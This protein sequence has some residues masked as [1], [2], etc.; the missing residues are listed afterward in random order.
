MFCVSIAQQSHR[1]A[2]V[3]M[4][5][6]A[7]MC[8]II[9]LRLDRFEK[10]PDFQQLL[11]KKYKPVIVSCR[12]K[13]DGGEWE[14]TEENRLA[15]LRQAVLAKADYVEI[16]CD[17]ASQIRRYGQTKRI[18]S[19]TNTMEVPD[20]LTEIYQECRSADPDVIKLTLPSRTPEE[21]WPII[22]IVAKASVPTVVAGWGRGGRLLSV[23]G[24]RYKA[25][26]TY[27]ALERGMEAYPGM[28]SIAELE[29]V[30][31][32]RNVNSKTPLLGVCGSLD[33][34]TPLIMAL[35]HG[36]RLL[37]K[38]TRCLPIDVRDIDYFRKVVDA[39]QLEGVVVDS[40]HRRDFVEILQDAEDLVKASG[41]CDF[42]STKDKN[43]KGFSVLPRAAAG[44]LED[45]LVARRPEEP[46]FAGKSF[47]VIGTGGTARSIAKYLV[48]K[49]ASVIVADQDNS[50]AQQMAS[51][52]GGRYIPN[53]QVYTILVDGLLLT[54]ND[55]AESPKQPAISIP[56]SV[57]REGLAIV[58]LSNF[59]HSTKLLRESRVMRGLPIDP[60]EILVRGVRMILKAYSSESVEAS[61]LQEAL[62]DWEA[63][64]QETSD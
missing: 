34:Q 13:Q 41:A 27:A 51:E 9:E 29:S 3:D 1:M 11:E 42:I 48:R 22:K 30:F 36:F 61:K 7:P 33:E 40:M 49:N 45:A 50:K 58:D 56:P 38:K 19:Y 14:G 31:D 43:W 24:N 55:D 18:I 8:D 47:L 25:P 35:N 62:G 59:P 37:G 23:L 39:I 44:A 20:D 15:V 54:A 21:A 46:A 12:R 16:E 5:N 60:L 63:N 2:L 10:A 32:I 6:A 4:Y 52:I 57:A 26:W 53:G 28:A 64:N 17:V